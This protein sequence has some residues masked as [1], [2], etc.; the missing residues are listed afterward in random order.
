MGMESPWR[1]R[2]MTADLSSGDDSGNNQMTPVL[3]CRINHLTPAS[4]MITGKQTTNHLGDAMQ[5]L[6]GWQ[7]V[8][9]NQKYL[10]YHHTSPRWRTNRSIR[11]RNWPPGVPT[12]RVRQLE[13]EATK[14]RAA[15]SVISLM[16]K[17][18][19]MRVR[20]LFEPLQ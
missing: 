19:R 3:I 7:A 20:F 13:S 6:D 11:C 17:N 18:L 9:I 1:R 14:N 5:G 16:A 15:G 4:K 12:E 10:G 2:D 8:D